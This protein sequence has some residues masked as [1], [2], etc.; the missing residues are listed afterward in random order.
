VGRQSERKR[1]ADRI[2]QSIIGPGRVVA[3]VGA[4]GIGKSRLVGESVALAR[5]RGVNVV[6][7]CCEA[8]KKDIAF[9]AVANLLRMASGVVDLDDLAAREQIRSRFVDS[10][11]DDLLLLDDLLGIADL[12]TALPDIDLPH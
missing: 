10:D 5:H 2:E 8:H 6:T 3:V 1:I 7:T 12:D 11:P 9:H 4:P